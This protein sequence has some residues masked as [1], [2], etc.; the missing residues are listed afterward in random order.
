MAR[1]FSRSAWGYKV[2]YAKAVAEDERALAVAEIALDFGLFVPEEWT[3][4]IYRCHVSVLHLM[5]VRP[6]VRTALNVSILDL[7]CALAEYSAEL[8]VTEDV[9]RLCPEVGEA[10]LDLCGRDKYGPS[11]YAWDHDA[12]R[13]ALKR[14]KRLNEALATLVPGGALGVFSTRADAEKARKCHQRRLAA[15][16]RKLAAEG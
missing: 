2:D 16:R 4:G 10:W 3:V 5:C 1:R 12:R 8:Y 6:E 15:H 7:A 9:A 14:G 11:E 13:R